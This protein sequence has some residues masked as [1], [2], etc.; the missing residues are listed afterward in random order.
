MIEH[1]RNL[2]RYQEWADAHFLQAWEETPDA[3]SDKEMLQRWEHVTAVQNAFYNVLKGNE[4]K[5][6]RYDEFPPIS[7]LKERSESI[8]DQLKQLLQEY[9]SEDLDQRVMI[10]WI[11][12]PAV[13]LTRMEAFTQI[14]MH[15]QHHRAQN[16]TKL[17]THGGKPGV[18]DWI[19]WV[20]KGKPEAKW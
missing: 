5:F 13:T 3:R 16:M 2:I 9:N 10:P 15:T 8:H 12:D 1:I 14:I 7:E 19:M 20:F 18:I 17:Q 4:V 6:S 11:P